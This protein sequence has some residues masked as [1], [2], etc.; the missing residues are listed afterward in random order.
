MHGIQIEMSNENKVMNT[1]NVLKKLTIF[2]ALI[3]LFAGLFLSCRNDTVDNTPYTTNIKGNWQPLKMV[4]SAALTSGTVT[5]VNEFSE[6]Q[7]RGRIILG[8]NNAGTA[9]VYGVNGTECTL[10]S[11]STFTYTY[12]PSTNILI[13]TN[14]DATTQS[15]T[16]KTLTISDLVYTFT[17]VGDFQGQSNVT[18][19]TTLYFRRVN[20]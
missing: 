7:Q 5:N 8:D 9:K 17:A 6:C 16:V 4:Q 1:S 11:S 15:G 12:D 13:I 10:V 18:I 20:M 14:A 19:T 3:L 2:P